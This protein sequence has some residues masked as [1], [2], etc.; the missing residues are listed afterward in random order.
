MT[1]KLYVVFLI[2]CT[3]ALPLEISLNSE[4]Y[5]VVTQGD[6]RIYLKDLVSNIALV[7]SVNVVLENGEDFVLLKVDPIEATQWFKTLYLSNRSESWDLSSEASNI[8]FRNVANININCLQIHSDQIDIWFSWEGMETFLKIANSFHKLYP[9]ISLRVHYVPKIIEKMLT[10][11]KAGGDLPD[12]VLVKNDSL[13]V[14]FNMGVVEPV[15]QLMNYLKARLNSSALEAFQIHGEF[16]AVPFYF[17]TQVVFYNPA[18][19]EKGNIDLPSGEYTFEDILADAAILNQLD[20]IY[21]LSF[22]PYSG[23]WFP[24]FHYAYGKENLIEDGKVILDDKAT[25]KTLT[26]L[27]DILNEMGVCKP[28]EKN[29]MITLFKEGKIGF[30]FFGTFIIPD[31][32]KSGIEFGVLPYPRVKET[33]RYLTPALDYKGFAVL[34]GKLRPSVTLFLEYLTRGDTQKEF[35]VTLRKF[36]CNKNLMENIATTDNVYRAA[37][38]SSLRGKPLPSDPLFER[39]QKAV[40]AMTQLYLKHKASLEEVCRS[41]QK[42]VEEGEN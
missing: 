7:Y 29:A 6:E 27:D 34:K 42:Y 3:I 15:S 37:Y 41:A 39:Y 12:I 13:G 32:E 11:Y 17:D 28:F 18:L 1:G 40:V 22:N 16:Y 24:A 23:Y 19:L 36:P 35:C 4:P 20:G 2:L 38:L 33:N 8:S 26:V 31:F 5:M 25:R 10:V 30:M 9:E 14:F 21:G